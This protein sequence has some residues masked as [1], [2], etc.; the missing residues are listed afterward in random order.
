MPHMKSGIKK[1]WPVVFLAL[2]GTSCPIPERVRTL[3][4]PTNE[5]DLCKWDA[6]F[7]Y[8]SVYDFC[9][10]YPSADWEQV[11]NTGSR[12]PGIGPVTVNTFSLPEGGLSKPIFSLYVTGYSDVQR[13]AMAELAADIVYD[14]DPYIIGYVIAEQ[15]NE[16]TQAL[17]DEV[18]KMMKSIKVFASPQNGQ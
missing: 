6:N 2:L 5:R 1:L 13:K 18:P 7:Y 4:P 10:R 12:N 15:P 8:S 16:K 17:A 9:F 11:K 14:N 3:L